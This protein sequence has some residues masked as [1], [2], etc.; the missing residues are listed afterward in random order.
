MRRILPL[1]LCTRQRQNTK[2]RND[3]R[4]VH[5]CCDCYSFAY[6]SGNHAASHNISFSRLGA[7]IIA[8]SI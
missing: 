1:L 6:G 2:K 8:A 5:D 7:K 3:A 4:D